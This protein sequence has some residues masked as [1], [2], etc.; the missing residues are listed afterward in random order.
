[1]ETFYS[2]LSVT[3]RPEIDEKLSVGIVLI[4]KNKVFFYSSSNKLIALKKL[5]SQNVYNGI[6]HSIK[7]IEKGFNI[8]QREYYNPQQVLELDIKSKSDVFNYNY[9]DY[10]SRYNN[11]IITFSKPVEINVEY[12]VELFHNLFQKFV[13]EEAFVKTEKK[14]N[15][16]E[17]FKNIFFPRCKSY[18]SIEQE[19]TSAMFPKLIMP[20][21]IDLLGKNEEE[22]FVQ[23]ID[24]SKTLRSIE[25]GV[26]DLLHVNIALPNSKKFI[27]SSEPDK[28]LEVNHSIWNN[29]RQYKEFEYV[30][31]KEAERIE[32]YA[33]TYGV[34]P[35]FDEVE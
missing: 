10:L 33:K 1:M 23:S 15:P 29:I 26:A 9:I 13:D 11:N 20:I 24:M 3:L 12:S 4:G 19:I 5:V 31:I 14:I 21:K 32:E 30:D 27:L 6:K 28:S 16:I 18:F 8:K 34:V 17:Q 7:L 22:V 25:N 35:L 2:I